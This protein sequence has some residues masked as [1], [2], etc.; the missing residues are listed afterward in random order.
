[1][2]LSKVAGNSTDV[3]VLPLVSLVHVDD[4]SADSDGD[5][6]GLF[7]FLDEDF[8]CGGDFSFANYVTDKPTPSGVRS[9]KKSKCR[10]AKKHSSVKP[11]QEPFCDD[12]S[13]LSSSSCT[14][15]ISSMVLKPPSRVSVVKSVLR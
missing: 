13:R 8:S 9:K 2:K 1:M 4:R 10:A 12:I 3:I 14:P 6:I 7:D 11:F 5:E 15:S